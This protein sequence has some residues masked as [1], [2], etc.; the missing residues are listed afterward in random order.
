MRHGIFKF[1]TLLLLGGLFFSLPAQ[2]YLSTFDTGHILPQ[3]TYKLGFEA[4]LGNSSNFTSRFDHPLNESSSLRALLGTGDVLLH[5][6]VQ[7]KWVPIPDYD[8]QPAIGLITGVI[9]G[10]KARIDTWTLQ[11]HPFIS[12]EYEWP[13]GSVTPY[14]ASPIGLAFSEGVVKTP[15]HIVL[16]S[17]WK[18]SRFK[19]VKFLSELGFRLDQSETYFSFGTSIE[20]DSGSPPTFH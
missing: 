8:V 14:L 13:E 2:S 1:I 15:L 6:G 17:E 16:G 10:Q 9:Y 3:N 4:Q 20:W 7:W 5:A 18:L 19:K 12:K 11:A